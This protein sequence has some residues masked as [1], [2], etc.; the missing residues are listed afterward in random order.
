MRCL[1]RLKR[2]NIAVA[3]CTYTR[4]SE[5]PSTASSLVQWKEMS[6]TQT[7]LLSPPFWHPV[8]FYEVAWSSP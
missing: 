8:K 2:Q 1:S 5:A 7:S 4:S 6:F 3:S